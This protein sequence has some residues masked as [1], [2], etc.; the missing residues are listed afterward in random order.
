MTFLIRSDHKLT[1]KLNTSCSWWKSCCKM[2]TES[3]WKLYV[4]LCTVLQC[5]QFMK[6]K[7]CVPVFWNIRRDIC[8]SLEGASSAFQQ[9]NEI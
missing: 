7:S 3:V 9:L 2:V 1:I 4:K 6:I 8:A 5:M